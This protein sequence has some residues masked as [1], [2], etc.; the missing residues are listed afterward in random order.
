MTEQEKMQKGYWYNACFDEELMAQ[1]LEVD[2]LCFTF[3]HLSPKHTKERL[4][5]LKNIIADLGENVVV[6]TPF[7]TDYGYNCHIGD[8]TFINHNAYLMDCAP[9]T[10]GKNCF[11]GPNCGLY[12]AIHP[13]VALDRNKGIEK[14]EPITLGNSVWLG[15]NVVILPGVTIG[16]NSVIGANSVVTKDIPANVV[17][18][19]N[20]C[21]VLRIIDERDS[22]IEEMERQ[23]KEI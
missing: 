9:I 18:A 23:S 22:I 16:E 20:P 14:A 15:G 6:L 19:G 8:D 12:T 13:L 11:L 5:I 3:N 17:A 4:E 21:R 10:I 7:Q 2:E 1:R